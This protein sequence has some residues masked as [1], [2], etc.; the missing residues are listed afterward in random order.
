MTDRLDY[1][2][3]LGN[4]L[5]Y[6]MA[7]EKLVGLDVPLRAEYIRVILAEITRI[8][9]HLL[10]LG[11]SGL[12]V[13]AMSV[14]LYCMRE[15]EIALDIFELV[16][17]QRMMTTYIRPGGLW[18]DVPVEFEEAVR[19][20]LRIMPK[21]IDEYEA[22]L[23]KNEIFLERTIGIGAITS[24]ECLEYGATGPILRAYGHGL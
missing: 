15:R 18:R 23:T 14:F 21:R 7:V 2:N 11:T 9:S 5:V 3:P 19:S 8:S 1:L 6:S 22:L 20:F 13:G 17:G 10:W 4:N 24:E 12:D 16:S